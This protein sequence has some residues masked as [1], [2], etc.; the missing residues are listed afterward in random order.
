VTQCSYLVSIGPKVIKEGEVIV[1]WMQHYYNRIISHII[2]KRYAKKEHNVKCVNTSYNFHVKHTSKR[3]Y[4]FL[5]RQVALFSTDKNIPL[6][7]QELEATQYKSKV[8]ICEHGS[9]FDDDTPDS[10]T[11]ALWKSYQQTCGAS[12]RKDEGMSISHI[13][14]L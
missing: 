6:K 1:T 7:I 11:R 13:Q 4:S 10:S 3:I 2:S 14:Y 8:Y 5:K 9:H 12:R